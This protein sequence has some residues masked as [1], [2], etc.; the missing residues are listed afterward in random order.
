MND[1]INLD[2]KNPIEIVPGHKNQRKNSRQN[3]TCYHPYKC[4]KDGF[5]ETKEGKK[6]RYKCKACD[7]RLGDG[8]SINEHVKYAKKIKKL[9]RELLIL[10]FPLSGV[11]KQYG[12]PQPKLSTFKKR[13][14]RMAY[15]QNRDVLEFPIKPLSDGVMFGDET[16]FGSR[17]KNNSEVEFVSNNFEFLGAGPVEK[18]NLEQYVKD[19]YYGIDESARRRLKVFV[20]DGEKAYKKLIMST[21]MNVIHV[22]QIHDPREL[23]TVFVNKYERLGPHWLHYRIKTTWKA[24]CDGKK[25]ISVNWS[26]RLTRGRMY[27]GK[28]RPSQLQIQQAWKQWCGTRWRQK[29]EKYQLYRTKQIGIAKIFVNPDT[30]KVSLRAGSSKWMTALLQPLL[31][32]FKGKHVTSNKVE[33]KHSQIKGHRHLRKQQDCVYQHQEFVFNAYIAEH[34]HLPPITLRG[35]YLWKYLIKSK[36]KAFKAYDLWSNGTHFIQSSLMAFV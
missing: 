22:Q 35:K 13:V 23:G 24:F 8:T 6:Q 5:N 31:K 2:E 20:S 26:I 32:I 11:A 4:L 21:G 19:A 7:S 34:G 36:K 28:G 9:L 17:E 29:Y 1:L 3:G 18:R 14:I 30:N 10:N 16:Y 25:E 15:S 27:I 12:I 33:G